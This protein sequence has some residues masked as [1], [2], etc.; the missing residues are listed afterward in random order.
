MRGLPVPTNRGS[1]VLSLLGET[2][3]CDG[4]KV[5]VRSDSTP[6]VEAARSKRS[7]A[8]SPAPQRAPRDRGR[9]RA[10]PRPRAATTSSVG[11][12]L[13]LR[14]GLRGLAV[15]S[16]TPY[17]LTP[18]ALLDE[19]H[20][21]RADRARGRLVHDFDRS[22]AARPGPGAS[23]SPCAGDQPVVL[24][25]G[26]LRHRD[27]G[28]AP[29]CRTSSSRRW[30]IGVCRWALVQVGNEHDRELELR[31]HP[32]SLPRTTRTSLIRMR[33]EPQRAGPPRP[34]R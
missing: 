34:G 9:G 24:V 32:S 3:P 12:L 18:S 6:R 11:R 30:E 23:S 4:R 17:G 13:L 26:I 15:V 8:R 27:D 1:R 29:R 7:L 33:V 25:V 14:R 28:P 19:D 21:R 10:M 22:C 20:L 16:S 2:P 31:G 5:S